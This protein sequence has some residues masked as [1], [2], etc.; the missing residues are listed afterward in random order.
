M[1][2]S[3]SGTVAGGADGGGGT[4]S[5]EMVYNPDQVDLKLVAGVPEPP[6]DAEQETVCA[7]LTGFYSFNRSS[8]P[9]TWADR[10]DA[11]RP[12]VV[13]EIA[14]RME[15]SDP[16]DRMTEAVGSELWPE[17]AVEV[18]TW[19]FTPTGTVTARNSQVGARVVDEAYIRVDVT[20]VDNQNWTEVYA[21][22]RMVVARV[23]EGGAYSTSSSWR[24]VNWPQWQCC[25]SWAEP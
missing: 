3:Q 2:P 6:D 13:G 25:T 20:G 21:F 22:G 12:Y 10:V 24:V 19:C 18:E 14:E 4:G 23:D 9:V 8:G 17:V 5:D 16:A 1:S 7:A 11:A 15:A